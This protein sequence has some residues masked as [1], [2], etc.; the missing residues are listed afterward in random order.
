MS[1]HKVPKDTISE[2]E[3]N[4][5]ME[6]TVDLPEEDSPGDSEKD[7]G[8]EFLMGLNYMPEDK[9]DFEEIAEEGDRNGSSGESPNESPEEESKVVILPESAQIVSSDQPS[10]WQDLDAISDTH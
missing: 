4:I 10:P 9:Y 6:R 1:K 7:A 3:Y 8:T 5:R 2:Q